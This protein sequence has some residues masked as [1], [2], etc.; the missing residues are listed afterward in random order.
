MLDRL[1]KN[2]TKLVDH[3]HLHHLKL[4]TIRPFLF[5]VC[6]IFGVQF[7]KVKGYLFVIN[8]SL[9]SDTFLFKN[10]WWRPGNHFP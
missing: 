10:M 6:I 9:I 4:C 3:K 2:E 7:F 5:K 1:V 8:V